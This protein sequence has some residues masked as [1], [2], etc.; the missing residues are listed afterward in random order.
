MT[1]FVGRIFRDHNADYRQ[2]ERP[3]NQPPHACGVH[4]EHTCTL[5]RR[6]VE[7]CSPECQGHCYG[8]CAGPCLPQRTR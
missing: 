5:C 7:C 3:A 8:V 6:V 2:P 4:H 1:T